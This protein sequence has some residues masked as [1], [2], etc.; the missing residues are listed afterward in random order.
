[1]KKRKQSI[2]KIITEII[3]STPVPVIVKVEKI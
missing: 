1:M 2:I 3:T